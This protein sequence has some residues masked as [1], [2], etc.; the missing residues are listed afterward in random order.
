VVGNRTVGRRGAVGSGGVAR[1]KQKGRARDPRRREP[2]IPAVLL[3]F[4]EKKTTNSC[5][6]SLRCPAAE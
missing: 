1:E 3:R 5:P 6:G 2:F 4:R